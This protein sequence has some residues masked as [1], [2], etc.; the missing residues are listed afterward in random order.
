MVKSIVLN[1]RELC[2]LELLLNGGFNPLKGFLNKMDYE[3]VLDNMRLTS[4]E[5]CLCQ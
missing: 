2:D 5:L 4:G 3:S 1:N